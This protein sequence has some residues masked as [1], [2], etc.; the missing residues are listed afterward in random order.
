MFSTVQAATPNQGAGGQPGQSGMGSFVVMMVVMFAIVYF[1]MIRPQSKKQKEMKRMLESIK[2][3]D[4]VVTS[5]GIIGVVSQIKENIVT[6]KVDT[7]T[8]IDF[9]KSAIT[10]VLKQSDDEPEKIE[11]K[12]KT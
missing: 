1:F 9:F 5:G 3:G 4:K 7:E 10:T 8:K 11:E 6:L 12:A 2:R